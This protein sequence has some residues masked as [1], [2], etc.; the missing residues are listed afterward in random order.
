[1]TLQVDQCDYIL[2][3]NTLVQLFILLQKNN[4]NAVVKGSRTRKPSGRARPPTEH[5]ISIIMRQQ[6]TTILLLLLLL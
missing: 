4:G 5:S 1:M 6:D 3:N 2:Y